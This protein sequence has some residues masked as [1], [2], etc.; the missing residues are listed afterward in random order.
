MCGAVLPLPQ[1]VFMACCSVKMHRGNFIFYLCGRTRS[2]YRILVRKLLGKRPFGGPRKRW[3]D[4]IKS[5]PRKVED[6]M[7]IELTHGLCPGTGSDIC[8]VKTLRFLL[9]EF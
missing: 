6:Q 7:W 9:P 1:Y 4:N 3:E 2:T 5:D 8:G